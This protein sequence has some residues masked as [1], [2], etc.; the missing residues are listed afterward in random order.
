MNHGHLCGCTCCTLARAY[1]GH[2]T[3]SDAQAQR[4]MAAA[5]ASI[6]GLLDDTEPML[7]SERDTRPTEAA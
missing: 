1:D 6:D 3:E 5:W 2:T 4:D 7:S